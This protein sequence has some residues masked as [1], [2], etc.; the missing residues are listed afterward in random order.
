MRRLAIIATHP[1]Q[2]YAPWFRHLAARV[3]LD[4]KVFYLWD[5]GVKPTQD[6]GFGGEIAWDVPLLDGYVHEFVPNIASDPGTHHFT[7]LRNPGLRRRVL[8]WTPD[9]VLLMAYRYTS[10]LGFI[11][12]A[13]RSL[14]LIFRGDSHR[15]GAPPVNVREMARRA[16]I[17]AIFSRFSAVLAVGRANRDYFLLHGM[18][19][20]RIF[21]S[22]HAVDAGRLAAAREEAGVAA[23]AWK[24]E[25]GIPNDHRVILFAGKFQR[26]KRPGDLLDAYRQASVPRTSLLFVGSGELE[27][28]LREAARA[29]P[30][31][32]F[33]PF[34][35][36]SA[37][38]RVLSAADL[39]VLPSGS[40]TWGLILNE[41]MCFGKPVIVSD[42]VGAGPDLVDGNGI[43]YPAG[44]I[45]A[46]SVALT[47]AFA[48]ASRLHEWGRRSSEIIASHTYEEATRGLLEA[49]DSL[50]APGR[51]KG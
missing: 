30:G 28:E 27:E 26:V 9:A 37:M 25:L 51:G 36:Q 39:V 15:L 38:P 7:G 43:V 11:L 44:D 14:P 50:G 19:E 4:I 13:P 24:R 29:I 3:D 21:H 5:F 34:Q 45:G 6:R 1:I 23:R 12:R 2:Y 20:D 40:E 33:A 8:D 42:R 18:R 10:T 35:N 49:L 32:Y 47:E 16:L 41:A 22:P 46:L 48:D 17:S 31:V